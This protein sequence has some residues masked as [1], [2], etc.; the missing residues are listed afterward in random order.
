MTAF[1]S[2]LIRAKE[3]IIYELAV[4]LDLDTDNLDVIEMPDKENP[5]YNLY[6][7]LIRNL[8]ILKNMKG[9]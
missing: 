4:S 7:I 5:R 2:S 1:S 8:E 3:K 9:Q 6:L